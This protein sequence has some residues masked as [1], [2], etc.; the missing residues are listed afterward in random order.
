MTTAL[1]HAIG[2]TLRPLLTAALFALGWAIAPPTAAGA[3][4]L[5]QLSIDDVVAFE[6][7]SGLTPMVFRVSLSAP[8][9]VPVTVD[10]VTVDGDATAGVDYGYAS[11]RLIFAPGETGRFLTVSVRGDRM[12][13]LDE[14]FL[15][16]LGNPVNAT[17]GRGAGLGVIR[18][19]DPAT[20]GGRGF[21]IT[22]ETMELSWESGALQSGYLLT[23][24]NIA[25]GEVTQLGPVA[26]DGRLYVDTRAP[27]DVLLCYVLTPVRDGVGVGLS[28]FLCAQRGIRSGPTPPI[29]ITLSLNQSNTATLTWS[30][31]SGLV[32]F[33]ALMVFTPDNPAGQVIGID[34]SARQ[35]DH[36]T[37]GLPACYLLAG[38]R[39]E[40]M[41]VSDMMCG[42]PG[43][44]R[45]DV[46]T[47]ATAGAG[48]AAA[49]DRLRAVDVSAIRQA[50]AAVAP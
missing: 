3:E 22:P 23:R 11:G 33:Y 8:S 26:G 38:F 5:P 2:S 45:L 28:D 21:R 27:A 1:R 39:G 6:G 10:Y 50:L 42:V 43:F 17:L 9:V 32:D 7:D 47:S 24:L 49:L 35:F 13:E 12:Y 41:G 16:A 30:A 14:G 20:L 31:P 19:D 44:A 36:D 40:V 25:T 37:R 4:T 29:G 46:A 15:V 34:R 48:P 18:N